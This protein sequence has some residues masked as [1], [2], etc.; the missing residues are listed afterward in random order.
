MQAPDTTLANP[1]GYI[2]IKKMMDEYYTASITHVQSYWTQA[3]IDRRIAAGDQRLLGGLEGES[4]QNQKYV[5]DITHQHRQL[6][7]GHQARTRKSGIIV[8]VEERDQ[9][10]SDDLSGAL[11]W[12]VQVDNMLQKITDAFDCAL[13]TGLCM[14]HHWVDYRDD[15]VDGTIRIRNYAPTTLMFDPWWR[16]RSLADCRFVWTRDYL[17]RK[18]LEA[19]LPDEKGIMDAIPKIYNTSLR[20]N[21][22]PES[23]QVMRRKKDNYA[24]DQCF[25]LTDRE[26]KLVHS[27]SRAETYEFKGD[28]ESRDQWIDMEFDPSEK[29]QLEIITRRIPCVR[30][31]ISVNDKVLW[32]DFYSDTMP[33]TPMVAYFDPDCVNFNYRYQ[34][35]IRRI[36]DVQYLFNRRMQ[37]Q[38]DVLESLPSSG[39]DVV[40]DALIDKNDAFK[41]GPGQVR[42]IRKGYDPKTVI[43]NIAPP[44]IDASAFK[45]TDDLASLSRS[46]L[47]INEELEG[48]ADDTKAGI[49]EMLRQGASLT[50]LEPLFSNL[51]LTQKELFKKVVGCIQENYTPAKVARIL[52]REPESAFFNKNFRHFDC[53]VE[54]GLNTATQKQMQFAQALQLQS[55][56]VPFSPQMLVKMST[57]QNKKDLTDDVMQQAQAASQSEQSQMQSQQM[58]AEANA[59]LLHSQ[60]IANQSTAAK[61]IAGI[62]ESQS[63]AIEH[64][65]KAEAETDQAVLSQI[66]AMGKLQELDLNNVMKFIEIVQALK[67]G[68]EQ[69]QDQKGKQS[70]STT[71]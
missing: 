41:T 55:L 68:S 24:Y 51:D 20:F 56:G 33:F 12:T 65:A 22:M 69:S 57:M 21:F 9:Q 44:Q 54:E 17:S 49:T 32:D 19:I 50:S 70:A 8:P 62:R 61:N 71:S 2:D 59:E 26:A 25:Y 34:G 66:E 11:Q 46:I 37:I 38:L 23:Y 1:S 15:P 60:A 67:Q 53:V 5:F 7:L 40:E 16:D 10:T 43:S 36:R 30:Q 14:M 13:V 28:K 64:L 29:Q 48:M 47:G 42:V 52:G 3:N 58:V 45:M 4:Y 31:A 39:V 63:L 35:I 18:A 6:I 27:Y